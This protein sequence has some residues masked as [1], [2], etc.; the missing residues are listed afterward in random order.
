MKTSASKICVICG[1]EFVPGNRQN[2]Q[3]YCNECKEKCIKQ[4]CEWA[5]ERYKP[6]EYCMICGKPI[7]PKETAKG[8]RK[9]TCS[10][11]C[12]R[13]LTNLYEAK[14]REAYYP[15]TNAP[16][17]KTKKNK[18]EPQTPGTVSRIGKIEKAAREAG[19]SYGMYMVKMRGKRT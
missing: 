18:A 13:L 10:D 14:K 8:L 2:K 9:G 3:E 1:K 16:R 11:E 6:K 17:K 19:M 5:S 12:F 15:D 4:L 7:K